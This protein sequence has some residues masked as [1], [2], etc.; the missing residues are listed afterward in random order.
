MRSAIQWY[1][2]EVIGIYRY[3]STSGKHESYTEAETLDNLSYLSLR[4]FKQVNNFFVESGCF[5]I[6][7]LQAGSLNLF[8]HE[9]ESD[10]IGGSP[11]HL[12]THAPVSE[13][14][15]LLSGVKLGVSGKGTYSLPGD[16]IGWPRWRL[17]TSRD[18]LRA[19]N[20]AREESSDEEEDKWFDDN[21]GT[22]PLRKWPKGPRGKSATKKGGMKRK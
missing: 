5:L 9:Q 17:L 12:F 14:I 16:D 11:L 3:G 6:F 2:G 1:L 22:K 4:V 13:F 18:V 8:C 21:E 15:Y 7:V 10:K 19:V 20:S